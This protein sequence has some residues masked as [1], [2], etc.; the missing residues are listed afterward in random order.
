VATPSTLRRLLEAT[1]L[2]PLLV[3]EFL[4]QTTALWLLGATD[5]VVAAEACL[6]HPPLGDGEVRAVVNP[7]DDAGCF[8]MTVVAC[9]RSGLLAGTAGALAEKGLMIQDAS[10]IVLPASKLALQRVTV[11]ARG[12]QSGGPE[13]EAVG[14]R[15]REVLGQDLPVTTGFVPEPPVIVETQPQELGRVMVTVEGPDRVGGLH[16]IASWFEARQCNVEACQ[17]SAADGRAKGI[18]V[19]V[20]QVDPA[21]LAA[22]LGG[23]PA[24][25]ASRPPFPIRVFIGVVTLPWRLGA[26]ALRTLRRRV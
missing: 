16:A 1:S 21:E 4:A 12:H 3:E 10:A 25:E 22:D 24:A 2:P 19:V 20:G 7:T 8:R 17:A 13:W 18:F 14:Q 5:Q 23:E 26:E 11:S 15:L 6:C 9:D